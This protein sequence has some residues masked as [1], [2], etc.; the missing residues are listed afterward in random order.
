MVHE[1]IQHRGNAERKGIEDDMLSRKLKNTAK[2]LF[3]YE[4]ISIF[5][6]FAIITVFSLI[7]V[8]QFVLNS[9][10]SRSFNNYY[11]PDCRVMT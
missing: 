2:R 8:N 9:Y 6:A 4:N 11:G 5:F 10:N 7:L 1:G 3:T